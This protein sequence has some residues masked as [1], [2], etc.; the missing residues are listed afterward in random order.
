M[1]VQATPALR[2]VDAALAACRGSDERGSW[3]DTKVFLLTLT[4]QLNDLPSMRRMALVAQ[5]RRPHLQHGFYRGAM[6]V[7]AV[8]AVFGDRLVGVHERPAFFHMAGVAGFVHAIALH[9]FRPDRTMWI[10]A[11][12]ARHLA[13]GNRVMRRLVDLRTLYLV[14]SEAD[15]GL[16]GLGQ[17]LVAMGVD[18][19]A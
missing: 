17:Y 7:M 11:I 18:L 10:M 19:V 16:R 3:W 2:V 13:L 5:E 8:R 9:E 4:G 1:T 15:L 6:R 12:G 14:A